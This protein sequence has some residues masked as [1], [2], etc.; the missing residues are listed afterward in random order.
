ME[1]VKDE[2]KTTEE[3]K[4]TPIKFDINKNYS[5][6]KDD[7]FYLKGSD[8]GLVLNTLRQISTSPVAQMIFSAQKAASVMDIS[9]AAAVE[10]G[11]AF[12]TETKK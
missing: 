8:F 7:I 4:A 10:T 3:A 12:E 2:V 6:G 11:V 5:W 1:I 9:L